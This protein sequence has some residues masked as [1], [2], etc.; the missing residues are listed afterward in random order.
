[1]FL[2]LKRT[3]RQGIVVIFMFIIF[4]LPYSGYVGGVISF[5]QFSY[6]GING[7]SNMYFGWGGED[8]DLRYR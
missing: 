2:F 7:F 8:D 6:D 4:R 3:N 5:P 1:M